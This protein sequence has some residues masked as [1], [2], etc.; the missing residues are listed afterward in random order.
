[1]HRIVLGCLGQ[2]Q[3]KFLTLVHRGDSTPLKQPRASELIQGT[4]FKWIE[5]LEPLLHGWVNSNCLNCLCF[6]GEFPFLWV[7]SEPWSYLIHVIQLLE[8]PLLQWANSISL[9]HLLFATHFWFVEAT[10][11]FEAELALQGFILPFVLS[12]RKQPLATLP[13][14]GQN[15]AFTKLFPTSL[16]LWITHLLPIAILK[17]KSA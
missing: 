10:Q 11:I 3:F 4:S 15:V 5:S 7:P 16:R 1:M 17:W 2:F 13:W 6:C 8:L 12:S 9:K 14:T